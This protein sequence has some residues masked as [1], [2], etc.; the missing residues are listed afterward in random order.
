MGRLEFVVPDDMAGTRADRVLAALADISRSA[1][2]GAIDAGDVLCDGAP[3]RPADR[4]PAGGVL[5]AAFPEAI[6]AL[7]PEP[8]VEFAVAYEDPS[9][10]VVDKPP[11]LVVHPGSGRNRGTLANG[12]IARYPELRELAEEHR[13]GIVHRLDRDTSGLL[14]VARNADAH[15]QLQDALRERSIKRRYLALVSGTF[16][17]VRGTVD[18][19]IGRDPDNPT[20]MAVRSGGRGAVT[21]Y[22]SLAAWRSESLLRIDLET[23]RTHQIRVHLQAIDHPVIGDPAYG[24]PAT[25][26]ADPGRPFLHAAYLAFDHPGDDRPVAVESALPADL[27]GALLTLGDPVRGAV[28]AARHLGQG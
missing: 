3:V 10:I 20:R 13:W 23:G 27:E 4:I 19:P 1:A 18:A 17:N 25:S 14:L 16:A 28:G 8:D 6:S 24:G 9:L 12:L 15:R 21:H 7:D 11:G 5:S 26:V 2:K 22:R